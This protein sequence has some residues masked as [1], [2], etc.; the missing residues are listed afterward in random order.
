MRTL[1][2]NAFSESVNNANY[3]LLDYV[4]SVWGFYCDSLLLQYL[5]FLS[6]PWFTG[7]WK[8]KST[9]PTVCMMVAPTWSRSAGGKCVTIADCFSTLPARRLA[10]FLGVLDPR[11][12]VGIM[13]LV[14]FKAMQKTH[15]HLKNK[16][17][18]YIFLK[19]RQNQN[20]CVGI[21]D[22][23]RETSISALKFEGMHTL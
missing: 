21:R 16:K 5:H 1:V 4:L 18:I 12:F 23:T 14:S 3:P 13:L 22:D 11:P 9:W 15:K 6:P 2:E 7:L 10:R 17:T 19:F 8:R 20:N